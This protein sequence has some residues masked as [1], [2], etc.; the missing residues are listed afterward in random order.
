MSAELRHLKIGCQKLT[1]TSS[2]FAKKEVNMFVLLALFILIIALQL[3]EWGVVAVICCIFT[4][5]IILGV[6]MIKEQDELENKR[7]GR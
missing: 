2:N 6:I 4:L 1:K 7:R 3:G 5:G